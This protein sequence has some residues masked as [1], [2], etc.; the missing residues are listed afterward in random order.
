MEETRKKRKTIPVSLSIIIMV[1]VGCLSA[2]GSYLFYN[3]QLNKAKAEYEESITKIKN[4]VDISI[5]QA[6]SE[7]LDEYVE[8]PEKASE[9]CQN[10]IDELKDQYSGMLDKQKTECER[11]IG[12]KNGALDSSATIIARLQAELEEV[13]SN[14]EMIESNGTTDTLSIC[15]KRL[16]WYDKE[17][18]RLTCPDCQ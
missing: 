1:I 15:R 17:I 3:N 6:I 12:E 16:A 8:K 5:D 11:L 7:V 18:R 13:K 2:A 10:S 14:T 9:A 4:N